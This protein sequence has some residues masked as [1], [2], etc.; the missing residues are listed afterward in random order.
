MGTILSD[1]GT[2]VSDYNW[3]GNYNNVGWP[4]TENMSQSPGAYIHI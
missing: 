4:Q 1:E 3:A 2:A